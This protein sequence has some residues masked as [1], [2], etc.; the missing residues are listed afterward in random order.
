M[1]SVHCLGGGGRRRPR[2]EVRREEGGVIWCIYSVGKGKY[3]L[4]NPMRKD[5]HT[6]PG[7]PPF[8]LL[9]KGFHVHCKRR[10]LVPNLTE[11][12]DLWLSIL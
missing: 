4:I 9:H 1:Y 11:R 12:L 5:P 6:D 7:Q 8:Y 10:Y 2:E 3:I